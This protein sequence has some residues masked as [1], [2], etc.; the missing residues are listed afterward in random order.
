MVTPRQRAKKRRCPIAKRKYPST[1]NLPTPPAYGRTIVV[2]VNWSWI[3]EGVSILVNVDGK[4]SSEGIPGENGSHTFEIEINPASRSISVTAGPRGTGSP[5]SRLE[6]D[7]RPAQA[8]EPTVKVVK[9]P[10]GRKDITCK[11]TIG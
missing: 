10:A 2:T 7:I 6:L 1:A 8:K 4:G 9:E 5:D 11:V 3:P